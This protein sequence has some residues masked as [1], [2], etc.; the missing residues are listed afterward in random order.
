MKMPRIATTVAVP[1]TAPVATP[2]V[3]LPVT[4]PMPPETMAMKIRK[5]AEFSMKL[6]VEEQEMLAEELKKLGADFQ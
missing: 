3:V 4:P 6:N 1:A 5:M 2:A